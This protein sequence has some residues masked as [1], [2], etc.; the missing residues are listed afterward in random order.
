MYKVHKMIKV[1]SRI[2]L[3]DLKRE[4]YLEAAFGQDQDIQA[5]LDDPETDYTDEEYGDFIADLLL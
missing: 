1:I 4:T 2:D 3:N 5:F